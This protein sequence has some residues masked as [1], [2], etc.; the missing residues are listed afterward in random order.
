MR[1]PFL[2]ICQKRRTCWRS[3]KHTPCGRT[4]GAADYQSKSAVSDA[5]LADA[6]ARH[7]A[8]SRA[9]QDPK[10]QDAGPAEDVAGGLDGVLLAMP[11][12]RAFNERLGQQWKSDA[13]RVDGLARVCQRQ[14][15]LDIRRFLAL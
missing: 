10:A 5:D 15:G 2:M 8:K 9:D 4:P 13:D 7:R 12:I 3:R 1:E 11:T 14:P 6:I